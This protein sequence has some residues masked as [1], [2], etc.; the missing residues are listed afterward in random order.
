MAELPSGT[1]TFV[2]TD[3]E[4][5]TRLWDQE[6]E[7]MRGALARH[8]EILRDAVAAHGGVVVKGRGDGIHAA[9]ATADG[10]IRFA[11]DAQRTLEAEHWAVSEPLRVRIGIHSGVAELRDGDYYGSAL[12]RAARLMDLAHGGQIVC[13]QSTADLARDTLD[14]GV[15]LVDLGEHRLRDLS[16][17]ERVFQVRAPLLRDRF[18]P[19]RSVDAFPGNL[20]LQVSSFIGRARE[21]ERVAAALGEARVVTLT[22]VGGIGK[23]R[24]ALQVAAEMLPQFREGAWLVELAPVRDPDGVVGAFAGVFG[25]TARAGQTL[26]ASLID[27][28][29]TKQLL[30]II[31]NCEHL[32]GAVAEIVDAVERSCGGVVVLATSREGLGVDGERMLV[33]PSLGA[34]SGASDV[35]AVA[36]SDAVQLFVE[37]ATAAKSDFE[38]TEQNA[39][40]VAQVCRRLDGMPLAIELAAARVPAMSPSTLLSRLDQR[41]RVLTGGR[42]GAVERHQTLRAAIDWSYELCTPEEQL[43]L[44][45]VTVFSG[46]CT[47]DAVE[48]VC[49]G[50]VIGTDAVFELLAS[51]VARSLVIADD[52]EVGDTRYRLTETIRQYGEE[53]LDEHGEVDELEAR[54]AEYYCEFARRTTDDMLGPN[55]LDAARRLGAE[56]ENMISAMNHAIDTDNVDLAFRIVHSMP[57]PQMQ[58]GYEV[59]IP[60][61]PALELTGASDHPSYT[62]GLAVAASQ[63]ASW[64]DR[65]GAEAL[66]ERA[67]EAAHRLGDPDRVVESI[68]HG[69]RSMLAY[70]AGATHDAGVYMERAAEISRA[71]GRRV[72]LAIQLGGAAMF[73]A[74][75]GEADAA[76]PLATEGLAI[77]REL[78]MPTVIVQNLAALA[79]ALTDLDPGRARALLRESNELRTSLGYEAWGELTQSVLISAR[80][81][82]WPLTLAV[83]APAIRHLHWVGNR[84]LLSSMFNV[85]AAAVVASEPDAAAV[86]QGAARRLVAVVS[87]RSDAAGGGSSGSGRPTG[88]S[89][90]SGGSGGAP[91]TTD[92]VTQLRRATTGQLV[93]LLGEPRFREL[94]SEGEAMEFDDAVAY[95]LNVVER[96]QD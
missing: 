55:Q 64:G 1:V 26:E 9:F 59:R 76:L 78:R 90:G 8:D 83:A 89:G 51:L 73:H 15:E 58:V 57:G 72:P 48:A 30:L 93:E 18:A 49:S 17:A 10:A 7:A 20:P 44:A 39:P 41:F 12:N 29:R 61:A 4:V 37:R 47:L 50:G 3:L 38:L 11:I 95:A 91:D 46:G 6:P 87:V 13:S 69:T 25:I 16:R 67:L 43:L 63:A 81:E 82:D 19:L 24:L 33:V 84:P 88:R 2:F 66:R 53:R 42:R 32:L 14:D 36:A 70:T 45:R 23:T 62:Y 60:A 68:T 77:A 71:T 65:D 54:H 28:L 31:D 79:A 21:L 80:L 74:M 85:V 75:T 94:R 22:G 27:F 86:L 56:Q 34:P 92:F 5:S 40:A 35:D 96:A 52:T